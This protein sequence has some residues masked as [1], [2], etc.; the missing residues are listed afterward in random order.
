LEIK[1]VVIIDRCCSVQYV[2][3]WATEKA[4]PSGNHDI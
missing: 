2:L 4:S 1:L 3:I